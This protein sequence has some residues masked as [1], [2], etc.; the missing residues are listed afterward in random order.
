MRALD[1][2]RG[3]AVLLMMAALP[4]LCGCSIKDAGARSVPLVIEV[5]TPREM[6]TPAAEAV[7]AA[8]RPQRR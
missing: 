2:K 3:A 8:P 6:S 4:V 7:A 5:I 1:I